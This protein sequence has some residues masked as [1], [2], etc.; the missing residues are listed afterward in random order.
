ME[1]WGGTEHHPE[2][3]SVACCGEGAKLL[4]PP[5][6]PPPNA[7]SSL[8]IQALLYNFFSA[9]FAVFGVVLTFSLRDLITTTAIS[10]LLLLGAGTF[11]FVGL[12]ELVPDALSSGST[13]ARGSAEGTAANSDANE[14]K[15]SKSLH[16]RAQSRKALAFTVGAVLLGLPLLTHRHCEADGDHGH[17]HR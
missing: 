2:V 15:K 1:C 11:I 5:P 14:K 10:Y 13:T 17:D 8:P 3:R 4:E 16:R 12:S 6:P 7:R 9:L